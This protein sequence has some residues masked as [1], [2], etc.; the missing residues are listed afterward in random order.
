MGL[1][2]N[3]GLLLGCFVLFG[4]GLLFM[5][6]LTFDHVFGIRIRYSFSVVVV[7]IRIRYLL[8][9]FVFGIRMLYP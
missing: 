3:V 2:T 4:F 9:V 5:L 6:R 1:S 7:G 8:S